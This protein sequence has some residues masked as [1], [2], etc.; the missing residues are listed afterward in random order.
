MPTPSN[1]VNS[2]CKELESFFQQ[3]P[4]VPREVIVQEDILRLGM[5]F[6]E[7]ALKRVEPFASKTYWLFTFD[8]VKAEDM[9][10]QE[11]RKLPVDI[12]LHGGPYDLRG[13]VCVQVRTDPKSPYIVDEID[14]KLV[15]GEKDGQYFAPIADIYQPYPL[16]DWMSKTLPDGTKYTEIAAVSGQYSELR[17]TLFRMCQYWGPKMECR[18]CDMNNAAKQQK[19]LG[20]RSQKQWFEKVE[21]VAAI[22]EELMLHTEWPE[23]KKPRCIFLTGGTILK[24]VDGLNED[25]FYLRYVEAIRDRIGNRWPI[26]LQTSPKTKDVAKRYRDT[27]VTA[28]ETNLEVWDKELF[29]RICPGKEK[30]IGWDNWVRLMCDEVDVFGEGDVS[31][32]LVAGIELSRPWGFATVDEAVASA[33]EGFEYM[34]SHGVIP[35]PFHWVIEPGSN[36]AK[37]NPT[38]P[39]LEYYIKVNIAWYET[40]RKYRLPPVRRFNVRGP[41]KEE[42]PRGWVSLEM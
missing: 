17:F 42:A 38:P 10:H 40:W 36:L 6:T 27:G 16:P 31:P 11:A 33:R 35:R 21:N 22:A 37:A 2:R 34:M 32:C 1:T 24:T 9:P 28:H 7:G 13:R 20:L 41:G 29:K 25:D 15:L 5:S 26:C 8:R 4:D 23:G 39:P 3:Y 19:A 30:H 18:F 12:F 14:G